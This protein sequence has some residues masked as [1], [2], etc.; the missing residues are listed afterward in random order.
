MRY[1]QLPNNFQEHDIFARLAI[2]NQTLPSSK[3]SEFMTGTLAK[4]TPV[5]GIRGLSFKYISG[6]HFSEKGTPVTLEFYRAGHPPYKH[7]FLMG[8][9]VVL[10]NH[11]L[12]VSVVA[13][14]WTG[15]LTVKAV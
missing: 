7:T 4:T 1:K 14:S 10:F 8:E 5:K 12:S 11:Q 3:Q 13:D 2:S 9:P 15:T 6:G